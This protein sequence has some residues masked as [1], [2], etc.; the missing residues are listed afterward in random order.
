M[1]RSS[2]ARFL[3]VDHVRQIAEKTGRLL[4]CAADA[5]AAHFWGGMRTFATDDDFLIGP[6]PDLA[7]LDW[8]AALGG[9]GISSAVG[10]GRLA[11][12]LLLGRETDPALSAA[13]APARRHSAA[14][15]P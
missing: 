4:A 1:I 7:G 15:S 9:Q 10:V 11:A 3:S 13:L 5:G 6:D 8:V 2:A 12:E 14:L